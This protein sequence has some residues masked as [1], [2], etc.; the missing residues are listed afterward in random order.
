MCPLLAAVSQVLLPLAASGLLSELMR[1]IPGARHLAGQSGLLHRTAQG[2]K[3][4]K[5][6]GV[7]D[8][9]PLSLSLEITCHFHCIPLVKVKQD[10]WGGEKQ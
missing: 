1:P 4:R 7:E 10:P 9:K 3:S 5:V 2:S 8:A 6:E